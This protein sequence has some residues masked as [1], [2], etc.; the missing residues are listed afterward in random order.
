M[1]PGFLPLML[2]RPQAALR[3]PTT[4]PGATRP[5]PARKRGDGLPFWE[6]DFLDGHLPLQPADHAAEKGKGTSGR[7]VSGGCSFLGIAED[8]APGPPLHPLPEPGLRNPPRRMLFGSG[9]TNGWHME[10]PCLP[11]WSLSPF[12]PQDSDSDLYPWKLMGQSGYNFFSI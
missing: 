7:P 2:E 1:F 3:K 8:R 10:C 5:C 11:V 4:L 6:W 9:P 12:K